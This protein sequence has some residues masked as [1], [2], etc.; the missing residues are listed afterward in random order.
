MKRTDLKVGDV[1]YLIGGWNRGG[2]LTVAGFDGAYKKRPGRGWQSTFE[3]RTDGIRLTRLDGTEVVEANARSL[4]READWLEEKEAQA[5]RDAHWR[6]GSDRAKAI[7]AA[8][9][10]AFDWN[11][12]ALAVRDREGVRITLTFDQ[13]EALVAMATRGKAAP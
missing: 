3:D 7:N 10:E 4:Q 8:L 12:R 6:A 9:T 1:V 2:P 11:G 5:A 13:A